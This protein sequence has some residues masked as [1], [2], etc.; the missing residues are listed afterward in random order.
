MSTK[1]T[2]QDIHAAPRIRN[3]NGHIGGIPPQQLDFIPQMEYDQFADPRLWLLP[4]AIA[5]GEKNDRTSHLPGVSR[6]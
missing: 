2:R 1:D 5:V 3:L 4:D 6:L